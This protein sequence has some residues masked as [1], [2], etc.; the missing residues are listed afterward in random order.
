MRHTHRGRTYLY[1]LPCLGEDLLKVG[2]SR[3]PLQRLRTLSSRFDR[4][5]DLDQAFLIETEQLRKAR[6]LERLVI[7]RWPEHGAPAPLLVAPHAGGHTEWFRG[8]ASDIRPFLFRQAERYGYPIHVPLR[9][10]LRLRIEASADLLFQWS[11]AL[12]VLIREHALYGSAANGTERYEKPLRDALDICCAV[13][14]DVQHL[15]SSEVFNWYVAKIE[16][17]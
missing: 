5:F 2:F 15:V 13:G 12:L 17:L 7:E 14:M 6:Q 8:L 1:V 9:D 10:W 16:Y 4:L 3:N 11:E